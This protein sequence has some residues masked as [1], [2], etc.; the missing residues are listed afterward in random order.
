MRSRKIFIITFLV[1]G[2]LF[3]SSLGFAQSKQKIIVDCDLGGDI[4][5]AFALSL[6]LS[7]PELDVLG[8]VMAHGQTSKRAQIAC[9]ILYLTGMQKIPVIV[10]RSTP[11][12]VGKDTGTAIYNDQYY[13]AEG[14]SKLKP[15]NK[16]ASDFIIEQLRLYPNQVVLITLAPLSN[17]ADVIR[18]DPDALKFAKHIYSMFGSYYMGYDGNL[19]PDAEWNVY[20]DISSAKLFI[21]S[22]LSVTFAGLDITT[23]VRLDKEYI[24]RL[25]QRNSPLTNSLCSLYALWGTEKATLFDAVAVGMLIWPDLFTTVSAKIEVTNDGY[26]IINRNGNNDYQIGMSIKKDE[27]IKRLIQ[28]LLWQNLGEN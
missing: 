9:K 22:G 8:I 25:V 16:P 21:S 13:W 4:D 11:T 18:K 17:I 1:L 14:F 15:S 7:S 12:V 27:F 6:I 26:T 10:G 28:R 20:A 23:T 5:D 24:Y 2:N 19:K 3:L